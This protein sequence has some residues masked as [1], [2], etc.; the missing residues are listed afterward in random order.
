MSRMLASTAVPA[1]CVS[2]MNVSAVG[3]KP[4]VLFVYDINLPE[5]F[6]PTPLDGEVCWEE[7]KGVPRECRDVNVGRDEARWS[8]LFVYDFCLP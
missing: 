5:T 3:L 4:D 8:M 1:G 7:G 6:V 2:Y